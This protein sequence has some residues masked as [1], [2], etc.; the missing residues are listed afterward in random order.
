MRILAVALLA[1]LSSCSRADDS[2]RAANGA[3]EVPRADTVRRPAANSA[4]AL[5]D[6]TFRRAPGEPAD[7][8]AARFSPVGLGL[9][10]PVI[11]TDVWS[12][13]D[14]ALL[15]FYLA[16]IDRGRVLDPGEPPIHDIIGYAFLPDSAHRY[17][18]V[19]IGTVGHNGGDP[20]IRSVF[21]ANADQ[22]PGPE[23]VVLATT[24]VHHPH[25]M[26]T[27]YET[28]VYARPPGAGVDRFVHLED[29][30]RKVSGDCDCDFADE[31]D[32]NSR[33][34]TAAQVRAGL[35]ALGY[36]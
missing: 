10:H 6:G 23:L 25:V 12:P 2:A 27:Y 17:R 28:L 36:R 22:N 16:E 21:F 9:A 20:E 18:R 24:P 19:E 1:L 3:A 35:R 32:T 7:S 8:F 33:F 15:A 30:S 5:T 34:K 29:V 4:D 31:P 14:T 13:G 11:A 26:G